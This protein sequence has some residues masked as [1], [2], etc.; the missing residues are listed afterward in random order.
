MNR[1]T[2]NIFLFAL[3]I[4]PIVLLLW[5][6]AMWGDFASLALRVISAFSAQLL[7]LNVFKG[8]ILKFIPLA[9]TAS[10]ALWGTYLYFT[11]PHWAN[12]TFGNLLADYISPFISCTAAYAVYNRKK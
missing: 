1:S 12:A 10:M 9:L 5:P 2:L 8:N 3:F 4:I 11:S 7:M 6:F